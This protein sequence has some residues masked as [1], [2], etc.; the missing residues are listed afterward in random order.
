MNSTY[1][2][3]LAYLHAVDEKE[4]SLS[5]WDKVCRAKE[6]LESGVST[7]LEEKLD[8]AIKGDNNE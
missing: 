4:V 8:E 5:E 1:L 6:L 7:E 2:K 3:A